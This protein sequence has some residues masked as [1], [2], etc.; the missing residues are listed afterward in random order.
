MLKELEEANPSLRCQQEQ[1]L[2]SPLLQRRH[3]PKWDSPVIHYL[4]HPEHFTAFHQQL[5]QPTKEIEPSIRQS[6]ELSPVIQ[7]LQRQQESGSNFQG[8]SSLMSSCSRNA[9]QAESVIQVK[10]CGAG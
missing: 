4:Q 10:I 3:E 1:H 2:G 5:L 7:Y 9:S 6:E 8:D